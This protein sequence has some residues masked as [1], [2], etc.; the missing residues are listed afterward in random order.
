MEWSLQNAPQII[1]ELQAEV[2]AVKDAQPQLQ[3]EVSA[4]KETVAKLQQEL[5]A[6]IAPPTT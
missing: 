3:T 6:L 1:Q 5:A 2:A 4:L